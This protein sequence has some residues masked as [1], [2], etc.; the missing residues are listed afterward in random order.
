MTDDDLV[1]LM[2]GGD[3]LGAEIYVWS[4]ANGNRTSPGLTPRPR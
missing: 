3:P 1:A 2:S 4:T